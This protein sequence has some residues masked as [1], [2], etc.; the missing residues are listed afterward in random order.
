MEQLLSLTK[1]AHAQRIYGQ[2][3]TSKKKLS[4]ED[5]KE[6]LKIYDENIKTTKDKMFVGLYI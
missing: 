2:D 1:I 5:L 4:L 3:P 6:G